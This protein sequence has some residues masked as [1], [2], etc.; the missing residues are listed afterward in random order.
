[1]TL[2]KKRVIAVMNYLALKG[3]DELRLTAF[4]CGERKSIVTNDTSVR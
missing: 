3:V 2:S 1:M 4:G